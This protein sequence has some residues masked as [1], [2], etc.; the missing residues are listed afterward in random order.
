MRLGTRTPA[1]P[2]GIGTNLPKTWMRLPK[3]VLLCAAAVT[4]LV[5]CGD[6]RQ[7]AAE[8]TAS[9]EAPATTE[10]PTPPPTDP[11]PPPAD[12][13]PPDAEPAPAAADDSELTSAG[14]GLDIEVDGDTTWQEVFDALTPSERSCIRE[15]LG[16]EMMEWFPE[17]GVLASDE[18]DAV[19]LLLPCVEPGLAEFLVIET[20]RAGLGEVDLTLGDDEVAC[21]RQWVAGLDLEAIAG[22]V[23]AGDPDALAPLSSDMLTCVPDLFLETMLSGF[24]AGL[25]D[26]TDDERACLRDWVAAYDWAALYESDAGDAAGAGGIMSGM[27]TC[28]PDLFLNMM[29]AE[30]GMRMDELTD[31]EQACLRGSVAGLD[32]LGLDDMDETDLAALTRLTTGMIDCVPDFFLAGVLGSGVRLDELSADEQA[33]LRE[34]VTGIDSTDLEETLF[35]ADFGLPGEGPGICLPDDHADSPDGATAVEVGEPAEGALGHLQDLDYFMFEAEAGRFYE[36]DVTLGT[37]SDSTLTLYDADGAEL[38]YND[39][40]AD[41]LASRLVWT[42][43]DAGDYFVA[44]AGYDSGSY[45]L[46]IT[47]TDLTDDHADSPDGATAVEVGEPVEGALEY[48]EDVD[49]FVLEAEEGRSYEIDVTLGTLSDSTL[50]LYDADGAELA[51]NDDY[52]DSLASRLTWEA[53]DSGTYHLAVAGYTSDPGTYTLTITDKTDDHAT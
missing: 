50:R 41:S 10:A 36:I 16:D 53:P 9:A 25:D 43:P 34:W 21:L 28:V 33:C 19:W 46:T 32:W 2:A 30:A 37:L 14:A 42:A 49:Y 3:G 8:P 6:D 47:V 1:I 27:V 4:L 23:S 35:G 29:L 24:G 18:G 13:P 48:G 45:T 39:D 17:T 11:T 40:Y 7:P 20:M 38:A 5:S 22:A 31:D 52:A 26:L 51:Y 15:A 12:D 44:V